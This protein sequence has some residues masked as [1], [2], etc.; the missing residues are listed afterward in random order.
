MIRIEIIANQSVQDDIIE[1]LE[2]ELPEMEY[3]IIPVVHGKGVSSH[4]LGNNIWPEENFL[5][6]AYTNEE[7]A[8][9]AK[10]IIEETKARF[11]REGISLF[12]TP[13]TDWSC[14]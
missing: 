13:A 14:L 9:K 3:T 11:P 5:L 12:G 10:S 2:T 8:A 7:T 1:K 6:F 4:K